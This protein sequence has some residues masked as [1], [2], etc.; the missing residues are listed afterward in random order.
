MKRRN[1]RFAR[2]RDDRAFTIVELLVVIA[3]IGVLLGLTIPAV[4]AARESARRMQCQNNLKQIAL[5][6]HNYCD[7]NNALPVGS[8]GINFCTWNHFILPFMESNALFGRLCFNAGVKYSDF[9]KF[10]GREFDNRAPFVADL[11]LSF[12]ACPSDY[13]SEIVLE[14]TRWRKYNYVVCAGATALFST[15]GK[16]WGGDGN[17]NAKRNWWI[18]RYEDVDGL[19]VHKGACFG[20]IRGGA[21][22][23]TATP[24]IIRNYDLS[25]GGNVKLSSIKD[26]LSN[27]AMISE[28]LQGFENDLR[29]GTFRGTAAFFTAY[30]GPNSSTPDLTVAGFE[31]CVSEPYANLPCSSAP[32]V[33]VPFRLAARS[34]HNGGVN[35]A[36]AD[37]SV[38]FITDAIDRETWRNFSSTN[39][40]KA[41]NF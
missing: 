7:S 36:L 32:R 31:A 30:C 28:T 35:V 20:V 24:P 9:G 22:D 5:S 33:S 38:R 8:K 39:S 29:G 37:G 6:M 3:I 19:V 2:D 10:E 18:D 34:R 13:E 11:R 41:V 26:G 17:Q 40:G 21:N 12:Y 4:Q 16:G 14:G 23:L 25:T 15:N 27:T 1:N